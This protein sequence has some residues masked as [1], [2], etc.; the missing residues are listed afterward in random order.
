[1]KLEDNVTSIED[2]V[3]SSKSRVSSGYLTGKAVEWRRRLPTVFKDGRTSP[4]PSVARQRRKETFEAAQAIHGGSEVSHVPGNVGLIDTS[5]VKCSN[6]LL[7]DVMSSSNKF[8]KSIMPIIYKNN[9]CEYEA[10]YENMERTISVYYSGGVAGK[11]KYRR[12]YRDSCHKTVHVGNRKKKVTRLSVSS[13][14]IPR[15]V[16]YNKLMPYIKSIPV[17]SIY[18]VYETLCDGLSEENKVQGCYRNLEELLVKLAEFYLSGYTGHT[19]KWFGEENTFFVSLG[20]D[21]APFGKDDTACAWL[22]GI[23][24]IGR[25]ILSSSENYLLFGANCAESCVPV[26][27]YVKMLVSD[28]HRIEKS[29]FSCS[30]V[31]SDGPVTVNVK[32]RIG[33]LPNDMKMV[34]FLSGELTNS[35]KFFSSYANVSGDNAKPKD[36]SASFGVEKGNT[37]QPWNYS[38]RLHVAHKVQ[39]L[40]TKLAKQK[41]SDSAK[42]SRITTFI[43]SNKSRQEFVPLIGPLV[44]RIHVEPLHLKNNACALAHRYLLDEVLLLS[45]ISVSI[46]TFSEVP[47]NSPLAKYVETM[48]TMCRLTRLAKQIIK[49]FNESRSVGKKFTYRFTGKDSRGFLHTFMLLISAVESSAKAG[50]KEH[51]TLHVLAYLCLTLRN[52][53]SLFNRVAITAEQV[54]DLEKYCQTY[55][56]INCHFFAHHPTSW[57]LGNIIPVHVKQMC[58]KYGMGLALNSMEGREAKHICIGRYCKNTNHKTRWEQVF[59]HEYVSLLWLRER[60]YNTSKPVSSVSSRYIPKRYTENP[61]FCFCG[62]GKEVEASECVFCGHVLRAKIDEKVRHVAK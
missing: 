23:L 2:V 53:V 5:L 22:V 9:L 29:T 24:N 50:T 6:S 51:Y 1:M 10:S 11:R 45:N 12:I 62:L 13:C 8:K 43:A 52:C 61:N 15:L 47:S 60:G 59:L 16:P 7:V 58:D 28:I 41:L 30:Y 57:T 48:R 19:I 32:F 18:S 37:W 35:A 21:G 33:E 27:R 26:Q 25:G 46:K 42:R 54:A 31:G 44:D 55:F 20:G 38:S 40:K 17:G 34:A 36:L 56:R 14:P 3:Q 49:W 4:S 39:E